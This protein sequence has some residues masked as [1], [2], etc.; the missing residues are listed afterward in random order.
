MTPIDY[1]SEKSS[2]S[3]SESSASS[4]SASSSGSGSEFSSSSGSG[5][6]GGGSESS[7]SDSLGSGSDSTSTSGSDSTSDS[8]SGA[9][10][11]SDGGSGSG[12]GE[13]PFELL[14]I[15]YSWTDQPD[16]DT[17]TGFMGETVGW[18]G[19]YSTNYMN[20]TGDD[21][22]L[23]GNE[24]VAVDLALAWADGV[25][26][27][28]AVITCAADWF[29]GGDD[30]TATAPNPNPGTGPAYI[31]VTYKG[32]SMG[33]SINPGSASPAS[34]LVIPQITVSADGTFD[35]N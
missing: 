31:E 33:K 12:P 30:D 19:P 4:D 22:T 11:S 17:T 29:P 3:I 6:S 26:T 9:T 32:N 13:N 2:G 34:T 21:Q 15:V 35:I 23:G 28:T 25:I 10:S 7:G 8:T 27:D 18:P 14:T 24:T 16:L 20:H 5:G 1:G